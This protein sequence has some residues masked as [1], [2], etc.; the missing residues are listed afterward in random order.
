MPRKTKMG[1]S[2]GLESCVWTRDRQACHTR[3]ARLD[4]ILEWISVL[5]LSW[6]TAPL[7]KCL[8]PGSTDISDKVRGGRQESRQRRPNFGLPPTAPE[9]AEQKHYEKVDILRALLGE[10][11]T[12]PTH[13]SPERKRLAR[14][15]RNKWGTL[16]GLCTPNTSFAMREK[17]KA[18]QICL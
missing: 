7:R 13:P 4:P 5:G 1:R 16:M 10:L 12:H 15:S 14:P 6:G 9:P 2:H 11:R 3:D 17:R 8:R 18:G